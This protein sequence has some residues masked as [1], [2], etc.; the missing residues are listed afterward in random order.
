MDEMSIVEIF[1]SDLKPDA[2]K[3][4][5]A[6]Y[7][8]DDPKKGN[9]DIYPIFVLYPEIEGF[10]AFRLEGEPPDESD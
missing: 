3:R 10:D 4:V 7:G 9:W 5:M 1:F 2:Q 8:I 6:V